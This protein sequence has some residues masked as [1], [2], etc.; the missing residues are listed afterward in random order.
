MSDNTNVSLKG[1]TAQETKAKVIV[2]IGA[3]IKVVRST[4][5]TSLKI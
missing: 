1:I 4:S 5:K 2:I 3:R